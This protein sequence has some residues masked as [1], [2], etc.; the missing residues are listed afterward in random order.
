MFVWFFGYIV[1]SFA[2]SRCSCFKVEQIEKPQTVTISQ[3]AN[4][5]SYQPHSLTFPFVWRS[6]FCS[7][8]HIPFVWLCFWLFFSFFLCFFLVSPDYPN[9]AETRTA[10]TIARPVLNRMWKRAFSISFQ[11][12]KKWTSP[13]PTAPDT[14][15]DPAPERE[16]RPQT[17]DQL[18][19]AEDPL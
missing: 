1:N 10:A 18:R 5:I 9:K 4:L 17:R 15:P 13:Q 8:W 11:T 12:A 16:T 7:Y 6:S 19:P 14:V 3:V 2:I